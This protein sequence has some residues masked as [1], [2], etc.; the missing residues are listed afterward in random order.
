LIKGIDVDTFHY[1]AIINNYFKADWKA[2]I[3]AGAQHD[4]NCLKKFINN[5]T[6][7]LSPATLALFGVYGD[8][9]RYSA[10]ENYKG[11]Y[12]VVD[13]YNFSQKFSSSRAEIF[14][15]IHGP[16]HPAAR[17]FQTPGSEM[18][19]SIIDFHNDFMMVLIFVFIF[20]LTFISAAF[21]NYS[22]FSVQEFNEP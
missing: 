4:M 12:P 8:K 11:N 20:T 7:Y 5:V 16:V 19:N 18:M 13:Q 22:T 15:N 14:T 21:Y 10:A 17:G 6:G 9:T 3:I 2:R 1:D